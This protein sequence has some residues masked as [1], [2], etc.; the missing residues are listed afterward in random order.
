VE[1]SYYLKQDDMSRVSLTRFTE[2]IKII[3]SHS[4]R[5]IMPN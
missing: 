5:D 4:K 1:E 3:P 2:Q